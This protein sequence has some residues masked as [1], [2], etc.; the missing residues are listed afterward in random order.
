MIK[1]FS[2]LTEEDK[3]WIIDSDGYLYEKSIKSLRDRGP[4]IELITGAGDKIKITNA[5]NCS[6]K[7]GTI[8]ISYDATLV[9]VGTDKNELIDSYSKNL[10]QFI[11]NTRK[12]I[13]NNLADIEA[14]KDKLEKIRKQ[15]D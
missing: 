7:M 2:E 9:Y 4:F 12:I 14:M 1:T 13:D 10:E 6:T 15:Y 3:I 8:R 5:S 11:E